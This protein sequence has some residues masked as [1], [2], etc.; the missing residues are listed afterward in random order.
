MTGHERVRCEIS[1]IHCLKTNFH[2][3]NV[4][5]FYFDTGTDLYISSKEELVGKKE[6]ENG[7]KGT[8]LLVKFQVS[9]QI[10]MLSFL[11]NVTL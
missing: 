2:A 3:R 6:L 8:D 1:N 11:S 10:F 9:S 7:T 5:A 4:G